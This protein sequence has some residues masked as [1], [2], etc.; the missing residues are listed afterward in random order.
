MGKH[1]AAERPCQ[2]VP[3]HHQARLRPHARL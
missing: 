3:Q 2:V 1:I